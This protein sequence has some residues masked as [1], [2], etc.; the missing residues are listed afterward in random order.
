MN[1]TITKLLVV[2]MLVAVAGGLF[3]QSNMNQISE[4]AMSSDMVYRA[5]RDIA[6][7]QKSYTASSAALASSTTKVTWTGGNEYVIDGVAKGNI[8][9]SETILTGAAIAKG[10]YCRYLVCV[11]ANGLYSVVQG[12]QHTSDLGEAAYPPAP[13]SKAVF[14][15]V[16]IYAG[17]AI[18][19]PGTTS[20][21]GFVAGGSGT[22]TLY[23]LT[24]RPVTFTNLQPQ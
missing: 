23:N 2:F 5:I 3:A 22:V 11:D 21:T 13:I 14:G 16:A 4:K 19:T 20:M 8:V 12:R 17:T 9:A 24:R 15:G 18:F 10:Y 7:A 1:N 6:V